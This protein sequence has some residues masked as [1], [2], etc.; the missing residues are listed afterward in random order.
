MLSS[1]PLFEL[2]QLDHESTALNAVD[3]DV[4]ALEAGEVRPSPHEVDHSAIGRLVVFRE[5][6]KVGDFFDAA[7]RRVGWNG[8][9]IED[10]E[11][12]AIVALVDQ[13]IVDVLVVVDGEGFGLV[14][15]GLFRVVEF[16]N[17]EDVSHGKL[18]CGRASKFQLVKFVVKE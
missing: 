5:D 17:V 18:V 9:D 15:S 14:N 11:A 7:S 16:A 2:L 4:P 1:P 12:S 8:A 13:A 3:E 6:V 10:P